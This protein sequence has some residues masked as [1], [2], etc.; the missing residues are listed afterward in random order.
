MVR[1]LFAGGI[2]IFQMYMELS[3]GGIGDGVPSKPE[4]HLGEDSPGIP[5]QQK[6]L[7][8]GRLVGRISHSLLMQSRRPGKSRLRYNERCVGQPCQRTV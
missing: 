8:S 1:K 3:A 4:Q 2:Y 7:P 5:S 6:P